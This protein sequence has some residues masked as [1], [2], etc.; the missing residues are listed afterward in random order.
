MYLCCTG[1][2]S[3]SA[4]VRQCPLRQPRAPPGAA[5]PPSQQPA[6]H[7]QVCIV[8]YYYIQIIIVYT[9]IYNSIHYTRQYTYTAR[10][11]QVCIIIY[12][13]IKMIIHINIQFI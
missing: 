12:Y 9:P 3:P 8:I 1:F 13:Y 11:Q 2:L 7:Q 6:R 5:T 4:A 10:Y